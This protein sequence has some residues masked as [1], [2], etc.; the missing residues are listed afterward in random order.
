MEFQ[1]IR[2]V[3]CVMQVPVLKERYAGS[4]AKASVRVT[5]RPC[6]M[7]PYNLIKLVINIHIWVKLYTFVRKYTQF[8]ISIYFDNLMLSG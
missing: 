2:H 3:L 1:C 6:G 5:L 7:N 4:N 8:N